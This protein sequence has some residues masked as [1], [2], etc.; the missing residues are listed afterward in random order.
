MSCIG[1][2]TNVFEHLFNPDVNDDSH[3]DKLL[4][5]LMRVQY[6]LLVDSTNKIGNEYQQEIIPI[7]RNND[8]MRPQLPLLRY[9]MHPDIRLRVEIDRRDHLMQQ[10]R[11]V[12]HE[13]AEH[14]DRAFVYVVCKKDS[15]LVT[16]DRIHILDRRRELLRSTRRERG[17][18]TD[19][20]SSRDASK[21]LLSMEDQRD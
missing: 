8:E 9:W 20:Q 7:I 10:I 3:I 6:Q 5:S 4:G 1:I 17:R 16:N 12:I 14:A 13:R 11:S 21:I 19:I 18:N 15:I 2:D